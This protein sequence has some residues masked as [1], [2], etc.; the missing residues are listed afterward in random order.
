MSL[1]TVPNSRLTTLFSVFA[2]VL[3]VMSVLV[4]KGVVPLLLITAALAGL[5]AWRSERRPPLPNLPVAGALAALVVWCAIASFWSFNVAGSLILTARIAVIFA[6]GLFLF[7]VAGALNEKS[8]QRI[9][10]WLLIGVLTS[11]AIM[12][13]EVAFDYPLTKFIHELNPKR[14]YWS[15]RLNRGAIAMAMLVWPATAVLWQSGGRKVALLLPVL[16]A[17]ILSFLDSSAAILG[18]AAGGTMAV[19]ATI[20]RK[21]S[22]IILIGAIFAALAGMAIGAKQLYTQGLHRASWLFSSAQHRVELWNFAAER[23]ADR[24]VLGWGFDASR[25]I[26]KLDIKSEETGRVLMGLHP[27]NAPLQLLLELGAIGGIISFALLGLLAARLE[28]LLPPSRIFGQALFVA[29]LTI[30][31]VSF[32]LWQNAWLVTMISAALLVPLTARSAG[33]AETV[34]KA[35]PADS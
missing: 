35:G 32:G 27:H 16:V 11:L 10:K 12:V 33:Q 6:A 15:F 7:A 31:C 22:R 9:G 14:R 5:I 29:T 2:F 24:P 17:V 1:M 20:H 21:V 18:L 23:I 30:S 4:P 3:P 8:R 19:L 25:H 28:S 26:G 34:R 13:V